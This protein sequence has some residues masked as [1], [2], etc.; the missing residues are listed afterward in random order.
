MEKNMMVERDILIYAFRYA[1]GR[2]TFA[3]ITVVENIKTNI[4]KLHWRDLQTMAKEIEEND[5]MSNLG[6][7]GDILFWIEFKEYLENL[8]KERRGRK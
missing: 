7:S 4:D 6:D 2:R 8:V 3:P 1:M 5:K